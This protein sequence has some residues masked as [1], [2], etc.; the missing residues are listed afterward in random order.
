[1]NSTSVTIEHS[2]RSPFTYLYNLVTDLHVGAIMPS[3]R[4]VCSS[5]VNLLPPDIG[6]TVVEYGA[7]DGVL[8]NAILRKLS[9]NSKLYAI[10]TNQNLIHALRERVIDSRVE[11]LR[12]NAFDFP[13]TAKAHNIDPDVIIC[14]IPMTFS[15]KSQREQ[16][17]RDTFSL[18]KPNGLLIL[19]Q[20]WLPIL[21][22]GFTIRAELGKF[23][24]EVGVSE[25][26]FNLPP[27]RIMVLR[28]R[29]RYLPAQV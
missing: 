5:I 6:Q 22:E 14:G 2:F 29:K 25:V 1:M 7:G 16:F 24:E 20:M 21:L 18:L 27:L 3:S 4:Q 8:T 23:F 15:S 19:Y 12:E 9:L 26:F 13:A 17:I 10:E 11:I 28:P